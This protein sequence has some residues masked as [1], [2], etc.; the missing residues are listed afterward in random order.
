MW[1]SSA[2]F[3]GLM[4]AATVSFAQPDY[5]PL[6]P[7]TLISWSFEFDETSFSRLSE[8]VASGPD[9]VIYQPDLKYK[10]NS[11]ASYMVEFSGV[12]AQTCSE[13]LPDQDDRRALQSLWPLMPGATA[14]V[15]TGAVPARYQVRT[16]DQAELIAGGRLPGEA[17]WVDGQ[18]GD[19][20]L[21]LLVS[22]DLGLP[23]A[24]EWDAGGSGHVL[25]VI[26]PNMPPDTQAEPPT[27]GY[28]AGLLDAEMTN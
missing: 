27:L 15:R 21:K 13:P 23:I 2:L 22:K 10:P 8:I 9:F 7:G 18:V 6:K 1:R 25:D 11:A 16:A 4:A 19:A 3:A 14:S 28:C 17:M 20:E 24:I 26:E 12:H 5:K